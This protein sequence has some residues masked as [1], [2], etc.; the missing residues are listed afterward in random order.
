MQNSS[1]LRYKDLKR[2]HL[3]QS[4]LMMIVIAP[5]TTPKIARIVPINPIINLGQFIFKNLCKALNSEKLTN[6]G[7]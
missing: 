3:T 6:L 7:V 5:I 2:L 1:F 4:T